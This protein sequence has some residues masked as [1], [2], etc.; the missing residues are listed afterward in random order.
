MH[1]DDIDGGPDDDL[2]ARFARMREADRQAVPAFPHDLVEF[3]PPN[4][5]RRRLV[6]FG[7]A[8]ALVVGLAVTLNSQPPDEDPAQL[9]ADVMRNYQLEMDGL[10]VVTAEVSPELSPLPEL[11]A[12]EWPEAIEEMTP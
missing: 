11:M 1:R 9:Y 8:A 2:A 3:S 7:L 5:S 4:R 10:L 6:G 12:T